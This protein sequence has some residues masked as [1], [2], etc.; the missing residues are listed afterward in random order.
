MIIQHIVDFPRHFQ[1]INFP[2]LD[3]IYYYALTE[4][5]YV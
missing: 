4:A 1:W 3:Y 2:G 5:L